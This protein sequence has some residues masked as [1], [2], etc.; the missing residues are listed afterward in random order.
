M[1][2]P[3]K[4]GRLRRPVLAGAL[5]LLCASPARAQVWL[6]GATPRAG[7]IELGGGALWSQG[8]DLG[9]SAAVLTRNPSTGSSPFPYFDSETRLDPAPG[10]QARLGVYLSRRLAIE[11][12][13]QYSQP[14]LGTRL[15][16]DTEGADSITV[17]ESLTRYV[18]DGAVVFHLPAFAGGRGVPFVAGG[19]GYLR[20]LHD[21][22]GLVETGTQYQ[23]G[24]GVKIW[25]G[26]ARRRFGLRGDIGVVVRDGGFDFKDGRRTLATAGASVVYLF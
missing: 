4:R 12:G 15:S 13:L 19:A 9:S 10:M 26:Q 5:F 21:G 2:G 25:F 11:G 6:G 17:S 14:K 8:V 18:F 7:S 24:A 23:A 3:T 20:E 22:N 1:S 16:G